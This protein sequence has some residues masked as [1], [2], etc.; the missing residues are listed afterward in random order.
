MAARPA[1]REGREVTKLLTKG[2]LG[3]ALVLACSTAQA[4]VI[5]NLHVEY[6]TTPLGIDVA[7]PRFGWQMEAAPGE[8]GAAQAAYR[9][10]VRDAK[11]AVV[12]DSARIAASGSLAITVRRQPSLGGDALFVDRD[13]L[14]PGRAEPAC[15]LVVRNGAHGPRARRRRMGRRDVDRR[16]PRRPRPV[17]AV[18]RRVRREL[19]GDDRAGKLAREFRVRR[20]RLAPHGPAQEH[21]PTGERKGPELH[22]ARAG[23]DEGGRIAG[24][25]GPAARLP[26]RLR[27]RPTTRGGRCARSR[28][29][30]PSSTRRTG[31]PS[32]SS[33]STARSGGSPSPSTEAPRWPRPPSR[34][35]RARREPGAAGARLR[36]R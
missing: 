35:Q 23:R 13:G 26:R 9:I 2:L 30:P 27:A 5:K 21:P 29:P 8:R 33:R 12:W 14:G 7:K 31:T 16:R 19:R 11:G 15:R 10:A 24:R 3:T 6:R 28:L 1:A 22:Q 4:A 36:T 32:T 17:C 25:Q 20:E 34:R 18:P